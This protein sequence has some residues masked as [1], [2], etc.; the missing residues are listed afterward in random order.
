MGKKKELINAQNIFFLTETDERFYHNQPKIRFSVK[1]FGYFSY[2][3]L[4]FSFAQWP[5]LVLQPNVSVWCGSVLVLVLFN[6]G[7]LN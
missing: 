7:E 6:N 4:P 3:T 1:T 2:F 5:L